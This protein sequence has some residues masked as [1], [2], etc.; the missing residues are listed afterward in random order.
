MRVSCRVLMSLCLAVGVGWMIYAP[1][2]ALSGE[3]P[4]GVPVV[5][6]ELLI[7]GAM[8]PA[9][10]AW[11][12]EL[13]TGLPP[14]AKDVAPAQE[15]DDGGA[16]RKGLS[17]LVYMDPSLRADA[18]Q[19]EDVRA[20][21]T[22]AGGVVKYEYHTVLP[23][24]LNL[25]G[26]AKADVEALK[27]IPGVIRVEEDVYHPN[28]VKLD[29]ATPLVRGLQSQITGAG[30]SA[31]G[32]GVRL[33]V[34]D[35]GIDTD[36]VMYASRIDFAASY[37]F[38]NNDPDPE[39]DHGH[40]THVSGTAVGGTGLNVDF[41]CEGSEP[42]QGVAPEATLI[43]AKILSASGGGSDSNIIAG[44]DHCAD[45]SPSGGRADVINLSIGTGAYAGIC[46]HSWAVAA[47]NAVANGVVVVAAS[48]NEC[49]SN[50]MG[51]P[52]CGVDVIAVGATY[53]DDY[54][55][56]EDSTSNFNWSCC[57]DNS[58][59]RDDVV[60]F[61]NNSDYLDVAAP[62]S[63]IQSASNAAGGGSITG[64]SGTSM[65][66]P[67]VAGLAALILS[68]DPTLTPA[69]V[70]QVI[71]DGAIDM[72]P[73]GFDRD[74]GYGRIDVINSLALLA[75]CTSDPQCDDG[76]FCNGAETCVSGSCQAGTDP[77][78]G[79]TCDEA[80]DQCVSAPTVQYEWNMNTNPG[81]STEGLWA[82][83]SPSGGGGQ[84]GGPDPTSGYTGSNV[85]GYN[86]SGDY[87]NNLPERDLTTGAIDCTDLVDVSV[88]FQRWLGVEQPTYDH[89]Y[90]RVST[91]GSSWT[92]IWQ[93]TAQVADTAWTY[94]EFDISSIA[95]N[96][97]TLYLRW[98]I[99]TTDSSWQFC[100]WNI[101]DVQIIASDT[102]GG[103]ITN[104]DCDDGLWCNG[105]ETCVASSCQAGSAPNCNDGVGCTDDSCNEGT[106]S[107]D[108]VANNSNCDNGLYCDGAET[109]DPVFDCQSGTAVNC[110]D[111]VGCTTDSCNEGTDSC[112]N[113]PS[114]GL[115]DDGQYCNGSETCDPVLDCQ[116]GTSVNCNDGVSC[117][118]DSCNEGTDSCDNIANNANCDDGL[119]C[120]GVET[121]DPVLDCQAG[122]DPCPGQTCNE[123]SQ[124]CTGGGECVID[125]DCDDLSDCTVD[126]CTA[127]ICSNVC[128][129]SVS[130]FPYSEAFTSGFGLWSNVTGDVFDWTRRSGSTPSSNT[131]PS[132]DHTTGSGYYVY[133]ETSSPRVSGDTALLEGPCLDLSGAASATFTFWYSMYGASMG[134]L[135]VEVTTDCI[136]W[137]NVF[138]LSGD[139]GTS[140][141]QANLDLTPWVGSSSVK[142]RFR[143]IRGSSWQG[144]I[145]VDD[146]SVTMVPAASCSTN[147]DCDDGNVCTDDTCVSS[148]CQYTNNTASCDDGLF[149]NGSDVCQAGACVPITNPGVANGTFDGSASWTSNTPVGET[150]TYSANLNVVGPDSGTGGFAWASQGSVTVNGAN[151]EFDLLSYSSSDIGDWDYPVFF[152]NGTYYGLNLNG[153]LGA[154]TTGGSGNG[155]T[156]D[157]GAQVGS[158]IQYAVDIDAL[159]GNSGPHTV[160]FGVH[161][162][163]GGYGAG[164]AVYDNVLPAGGPIDPCPGQTCDE[165]NDVCVP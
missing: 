29:E 10:N 74:Y 34:C 141:Y 87:E 33:C 151:L 64:M 106:D 6:T 163:D 72:G 93:N 121:C 91:N 104:G 19:R 1:P 9:S 42:F 133:T 63:V 30:Y 112:D 147:G 143:G 52:A 116:S 108:N 56:C 152:L 54:P 81:W 110:N 134:T 117:T 20:L 99:G 155:G 17:V 145:A 68:A 159:A 40:G 126:T 130:T 128:S 49:N 129:S 96:Q 158:T 15:P 18:V 148:V 135:E 51:S 44:I 118:D 123:G 60:C 70:R 35:T 132:G 62:G 102:G 53:K 161:S 136:S 31:D 66:S 4:A 80:N 23:N 58:P 8:L 131:G 90:F 11:G 2:V 154:A 27:R 12:A 89:A 43:G 57:T 160:G 164:T 153:T 105:A 26:L 84:Y 88:A 157:N 138:G 69:E 22:K 3:V 140:W 39:D 82:W 109:C 115:C 165:V 79:Q 122:S 59:R 14:G 41:G 38:H 32:S 114:N 46:T 24:V 5:T 16:E 71:R 103:C 25:R 97:P 156:V 78:P 107:C 36:H 86:L 76:L 55:N 137:T 113:I 124:T 73:A 120:T 21:A 162:V 142:V 92:T 47:N 85:F 7:D 127:G 125:D 77:C 45:Q 67:M 75:P 119:F 13:E 144:D 139:Q 146:I 95:D 28:L 37:D 48:G 150:I 149:C 83:G 101:D 98:T 100:G 94:Q 61:S 50:A 111:G 65:A